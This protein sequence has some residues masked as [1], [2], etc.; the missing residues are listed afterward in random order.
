[1]VSQKDTR[2]VKDRIGNEDKT[3]KRTK[4]QKGEAKLAAGDNHVVA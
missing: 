1:M 3:G 4:Q 2:L